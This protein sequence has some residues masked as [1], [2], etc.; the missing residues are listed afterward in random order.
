MPRF[1]ARVRRVFSPGFKLRIT[2]LEPKLD[3]HDE[4]DWVNKDLPVGCCEYGHGKSLITTDR[5]MFSHQVQGGKS[6]G[7]C[8]YVIYPRMG[9][10]WALFKNWDIRW[11]SISEHHG[12][13]KFEIV[14]VLSDFNDNDGIVVAYLDKI[15]GFVS[16]FQKTRR[17]GIVLF[18]IPSKEHFRFSHQIPSVR[19]TGTERGGVPVG[20]LELDPAA[21]PADLN[22]FELDSDVKMKRKVLDSKLTGEW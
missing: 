21:L 12:N 17:E 1:Y 16:L 20:S 9:E 14:E 7:K 4:I 8:S 11:S 15:K 22:E 18:K 6:S 5:L 19:M 10:T 13:F 2:W 3:G